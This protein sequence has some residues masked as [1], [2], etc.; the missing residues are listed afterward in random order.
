MQM[1]GGAKR[2][3]S[4]SPTLVETFGAVEKVGSSVPVAAIAAIRR[5]GV[6]EYLL[7]ITPP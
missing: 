2:L 1:Y 5:T 3:Q 7:R 4:T 6:T